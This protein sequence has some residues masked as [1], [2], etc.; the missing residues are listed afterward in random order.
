MFAHPRV[1]LQ[2][3]FVNLLCCWIILV[4]SGIFDLNTIKIFGMCPAGDGRNGQVDKPHLSFCC[5]LFQKKKK[6]KDP[7]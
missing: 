7:V 4:Q 1:G 2:A 3:L 5:T 6:K